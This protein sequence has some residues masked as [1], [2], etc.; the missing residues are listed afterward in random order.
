[1][2][3]IDANCFKGCDKI[4]KIVGLHHGIT[5]KT[6]FYDFDFKPFL[7][8]FESYKAD[9]VQEVYKWQQKRDF[10]TTAEYKA[11]VTPENQ[12]KKVQEYLA[13][14][15]KEGFLDDGWEDAG[16]YPVKGGKA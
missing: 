7:E 10:E 1:M 14:A 15:I 11:R 13:K 6:G 4:K 9:A 16:V 12:Q 5:I 8:D 3:E 2:K